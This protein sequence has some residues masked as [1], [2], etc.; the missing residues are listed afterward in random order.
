MATS[1]RMENQSAASQVFAIPELLE[2]ILQHLP[3]KDLLLSQRVAKTWQQ[4]TIGSPSLRKTLFLEAATPT[5]AW[6]VDHHADIYP[7]IGLCA[8]NRI[9]AIVPAGDYAAASYT[10]DTDENDENVKYPRDTRKLTLVAQLNPLILKHRSSSPVRKLHLRA[11]VGENVT[12]TIP[13]PPWEGAQEML[14][15]QPPGTEAHLGFRGTRWGY[16]TRLY[17]PHG[18][19]VG[20]A[21]AE[22]KKCDKDDVSLDDLKSLHL[23][24]NGVI[25]PREYEVKEIM[26][27]LEKEGYA[28]E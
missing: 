26:E 17:N 1:T 22:M 2:P 27:K 11:W 14:F 13:I 12:M 19:T 15:T 4:T 18:V 28:S 8:S 5:T 24:L 10:L 25:S 9:S 21:W 23:S 3:I 16:G 20:D 7:R 6:I